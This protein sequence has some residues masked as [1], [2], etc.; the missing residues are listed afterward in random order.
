VDVVLGITLAPE[1]LPVELPVLE[2]VL[3]PPPLLVPV[4]EAAPPVL[5]ELAALL[6]PPPLDV[7]VEVVVATGQLG[8]FATNAARSIEPQPLAR[9]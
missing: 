8:Q 2:P 9:S 4:L 6:E 1:E 5:E 7:P 3:L